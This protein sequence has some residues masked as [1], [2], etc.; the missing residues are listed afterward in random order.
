[1]PDGRFLTINPRRTPGYRVFRGV[2]TFAWRA[3]FRPS[4]S[5][6]ENIPREGAVIIAPTHH[7]NLDFAFTIFMTRRKA[8]FMAKDSLWR[9]AVLGKLISTMGAFP[10]KRGTA[11]RES[12]S[13]AQHVLEAGEPLVLFPEGTRQLTHAV[14][15]LHDGAMYLAARTGAPIV[16]IGIGNTDR[17]MPKGAKFPRPVKVRIVIGSP[18]SAPTADGRLTR[19]QVAAATA[20]LKE[21]LV[22]VYARATDA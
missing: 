22:D 3:F 4:V 20:Q 10:V 13:H 2:L 11:D 17:A 15:E 6:R 5:G 1:M 19:S 21:A 7:S 16:P 14:G 9:V 12:M 8:F 18:L